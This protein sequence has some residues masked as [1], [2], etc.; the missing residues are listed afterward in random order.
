MSQLLPGAGFDVIDRRLNY[1][2]TDARWQ[3]TANYGFLPNEAMRRT[4][5][6]VT[7]D[8]A[9]E[10]ADETNNQSKHVA[11]CDVTSGHTVTVLSVANITVMHCA[12]CMVASQYLHNQCRSNLASV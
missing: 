4:F 7:I 11:R 1:R 6:A 10:M 9:D 5:L 2:Y 8:L 3:Q 12:D